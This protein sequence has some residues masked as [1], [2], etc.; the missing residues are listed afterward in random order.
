MDAVACMVPGIRRLPIT[1]MKEGNLMTFREKIRFLRER[2]GMTQLELAKQLGI[3]QNRVSQF[4]N[5][6]K[7]GKEVKIEPTLL[8]RIAD[9]FA[10]PIHW[11]VDP[12][13][14]LEQIQDRPGEADRISSVERQI[15]LNARIL[16]PSLALARLLGVA[17]ADLAKVGIDLQSGTLAELAGH[18]PAATL[19]KDQVPQQKA[20][21]K[22]PGPGNGGNG[23]K[24]KPR[25]PRKRSRFAHV[26]AKLARPKKKSPGAPK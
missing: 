19:K 18:E 16:G 22:P 11:L 17:P 3:W 5:P 14:D 23:T 6:P 1:A 20:P 24:K 26:G 25:R 8:V 12:S 15:L 13:L 2:E 7:R 21:D 4:E 9:F 10:V